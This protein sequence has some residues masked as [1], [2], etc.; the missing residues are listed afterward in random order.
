MFYFFPQVSSALNLPVCERTK[1]YVS[2]ALCLCRDIPL[3]S[4]LARL[5]CSGEQRNSKLH[6]HPV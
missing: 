6:L 4:K 5:H 2:R 1:L 3:S